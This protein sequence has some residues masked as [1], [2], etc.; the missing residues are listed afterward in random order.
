MSQVVKLT[1]EVSERV[2]HTEVGAAVSTIS[3]NLPEMTRGVK[4]IAALMTEE[5]R[6]D[7]LI[8]AT[9][10]L[11]GAFSDFLNSV[12]PDHK[13]VILFLS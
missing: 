8:G 10:K 6:G 7:D 9:R 3:S 11:C 4:T 2:D 12:N 5:E 13:E 1:G